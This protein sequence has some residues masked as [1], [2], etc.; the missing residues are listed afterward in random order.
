MPKYTLVFVGGFTK[1][2]GIIETASNALKENISHVAGILSGKCWEAQ[3]VV[4]G[5]ENYPGFWEQRMDRLVGVPCTRFVAVEVPDLAPILAKAKQLEGTPYGYTDCIR[6]G[7]Y[8]LFGGQIPD[9]T[10]TMDC[11]E[12]QTRLLR[13][14]REVLPGREAGTITPIDLYRYVREVLH[15]EDITG[16]VEAGNCI[17]GSDFQLPTGA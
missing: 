1:I 3:G 13:S 4:L 6:G 2:D 5:N 7:V 8:D 15:G 17:P 9:N 14:V 16:L 10:L 11:S 12:A